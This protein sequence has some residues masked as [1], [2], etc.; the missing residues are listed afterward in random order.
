LLFILG[1]LPSHVIY[2]QPKAMIPT[3]HSTL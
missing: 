1:R 2:Q 3:A